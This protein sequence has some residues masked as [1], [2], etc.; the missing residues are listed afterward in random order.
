VAATSKRTGMGSRAIFTADVADNY[1]KHRRGYLTESFALRPGSRV[2]DLGCGTGQ[3]TI[4]LA[5]E[6]GVVIGMDP[7]PDMLARADTTAST[8]TWVFGS[9][10][11]VPALEALLGKESLDLVTI[12]QA[13]HWMDAPALS[14][15]LAP[16]LRPGGGVAV[17]SN[18]TARGTGACSPTPA[19]SWRSTRPTIRRSP[20]STRSSA[21]STPPPRWSGSTPSSVWASE[22]TSA[23]HCARPS[24]TA[25]SSKT[26]PYAH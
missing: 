7:S 15:A 14:G 1:A 12:A 6:A 20:R 25:G 5:A 9:D 2:L 11:Q 19:T 13:L 8:V 10:K 23:R 24:R 22:R 4:P 17:I 16:L 26:F 18:G 3:L 21:P